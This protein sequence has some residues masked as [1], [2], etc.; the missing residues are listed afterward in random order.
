MHHS[1]IMMSG[2]TQ[3][4]PNFIDRVTS[5][6]W[7]FFFSG[8]SHHLWT[9]VI[10]RT[11]TL[12]KKIKKKLDQR[13]TNT[14]YFSNVSL[15]SRIFLP[16]FSTDD[17]FIIF[18]LPMIDFPDFRPT[19]EWCDAWKKEGRKKPC[20]SSPNNFFHSL[21]S[22]KFAL[23]VWFRVTQFYALYYFFIWMYR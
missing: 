15:F 2:N 13:F 21:F 7:W 16:D 6:T 8:V 3:N 23:N 11:M 9:F 17:F 12:K 14:N 18:L 4:L 10:W 19:T 22:G 1:S 20:A 5:N